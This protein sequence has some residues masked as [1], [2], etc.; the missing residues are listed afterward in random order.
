V[1]RRELLEDLLDQDL[2]ADED[3]D[4][5]AAALLRHPDR[6]RRR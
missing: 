6:W 5:L 3:Q 4:P 1:T 2:E